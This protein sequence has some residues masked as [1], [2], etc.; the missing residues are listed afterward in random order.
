MKIEKCGSYHAK[1]EGCELVAMP[2][3]KSAFKVYFVSI[4]G[5]D[6][7]SRTEWALCGIDKQAFIKAFR[8]SGQEGVGF[9]TAFPHIT[10]V[11]RYA[12]KSEVLLHV[13]AFKPATGEAIS[14]DRGE[15]YTEFACLAEAVVANDEFKA[16]AKA[17]TVKEYLSFTSSEKDLPILSNTKLAEYVQEKA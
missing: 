1:I 9:L 5:R 7:P 12:P 10:K 11:F 16:W 13:T 3:G 14:L 6:N 17:P 4:V 8:E 2:D 15:G